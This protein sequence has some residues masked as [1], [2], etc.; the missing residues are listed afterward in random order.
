MIF[1]T[2]DFNN[3]E[4]VFA[5]ENF[6]LVSV[7]GFIKYILAFLYISMSIKAKPRIVSGIHVFYM[8]CEL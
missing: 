2:A 4:R 8:D 1:A 7:Y 3:S 5:F 6:V